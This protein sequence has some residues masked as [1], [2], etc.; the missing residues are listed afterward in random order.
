[1]AHGCQSYFLTQLVDLDDVCSYAWVTAALAYLY[2]QLGLATQH[3]VKQ[4]ASYLT[5]LEAWVYEHFECLA[6]T[7]NIHHIPDSP[8]SIDG[9]LVGSLLV[10]K[11]YER[12]LIP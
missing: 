10:Y 4:I 6:L 2:K 5:L 12:D 3:E 7:P 1:M 9:S 11:H 8:G